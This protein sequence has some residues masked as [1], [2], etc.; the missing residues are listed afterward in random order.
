MNSWLYSQTAWRGDAGGPGPAMCFGGCGAQAATEDCAVQVAS[1][2]Y[3]Q[4]DCPWCLVFADGLQLQQ[5]LASSDF[6][7]AAA[8]LAINQD[9]VLADHCSGNRSRANSQQAWG[10]SCWH[11]M[12]SNLQQSQCMTPCR[13]T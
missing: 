12:N 13:P 8:K 10:Q 9:K 4:A 6:C 2:N 3:L 11:N 1:E 5:L 7:L